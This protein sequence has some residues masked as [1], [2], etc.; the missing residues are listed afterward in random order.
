MVALEARCSTAKTSKSKPHQAWAAIVGLVSTRVAELWLD[1]CE[2]YD[3]L[4][5]L[6]A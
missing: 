1:G 4:E 2:I 5:A 6:I 3:A